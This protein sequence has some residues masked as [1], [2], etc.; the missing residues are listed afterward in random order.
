MI[1]AVLTKSPK[2]EKRF[3]VIVED[4]KRK[5]TIHFGSG[6]PAGKGAFIDHKDPKIKDAWE[7]RHKVREDWNDPFTAGFWSKWVLWNKE[8]LEDSIEDLE[9][10]YSIEIN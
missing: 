10:K 5:K 7:A 3:K 4:D 8:T 2:S 1:Q 6:K 9:K